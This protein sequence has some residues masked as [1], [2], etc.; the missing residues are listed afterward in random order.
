MVTARKLVTADELYAMGDDQRF[1]LIDG[2]LIEMAPV[3]EPHGETLIN[4][5]SLLN[6]FVKERRLGKVV[7]G[8]IGVI[9]G[10]SPDTVL[11]PDVAFISTTRM[12][13]RGEAEGFLTSAPDLAV[14]ILSP[15][16]T[17]A[18]MAFKVS[19]Y[20]AAGSRL[21]WVVDPKAR[22]VVAYAPGREPLVF[23]AEANLTAD[24]VLPGFTCR[25]A[26]LFD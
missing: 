17:S 24:D 11:A 15:S 6:R 7:G 5:G 23:S 19:R 22:T 4:L 2:E 14:E 3:G 12:R 1:E 20:L 13:P 25:V 18:E 8:D 16:N 21:V 9:V 26:E 10:R